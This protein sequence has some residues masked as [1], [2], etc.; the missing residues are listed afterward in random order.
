MLDRVTTVE[1]AVAG[2]VRSGQTL[3]VGGFGRGGVPFTTLHL[4]ANHADKYRDL[5]LIKND[6][7]EPGIGIDLLLKQGQVKK[8]IAT[9]IG[10]NPEFI[11]QMNDGE[12]ECELIPQGIFAEKIRAGG[13]GI[14]A[15]MT[16]I[17]LGT[18]VAQGKATYELDG[19]TLL[20]EP[21][22][23]GDVALVCADIADKAGN[24]WWCGSNRNMCVVMGTACKRVIVEAKQIVETGR[25][26]AEDIHLPSVFVDA[27]VPAGPL[28]HRGN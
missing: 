19:K 22:M 18:E 3:M 21:C 4:I 10:L 20:I 12:V 14:P 7:N 13:A 25:L 26:K 17:G 28:P 24:A 5:T 27:V 8:L 2:Y 9:H 15:I 11:R 16:D 6:A 23:R 1:N